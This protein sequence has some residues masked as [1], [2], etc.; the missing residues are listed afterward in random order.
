LTRRILL[1][2]LLLLGLPVAA[3]DDDWPTYRH[4]IRRSGATTASLTLPLKPRWS[5]HA[6]QPRQAWSGPA[7]WDAF[8]A[9]AGLQSMRNFDPCHHLT[10]TGDRVY[11]GSSADDAAHCLDAATGKLQWTFFTNAPVR[12][13]PTISNNLAYFGSDDGHAYCVDASNGNL[14]WKHRPASDHRLVA[15]NENL[16]SPWPIRTGVLVDRGKAWFAASLVPWE[17]SYLCCLDAATGS[18]ENGFITEHRELTLQ[19]AMLAAGDL[20]YVPQGRSA[21]LTFNRADG[22]RGSAIGHAGG[23]LCVLTEGN[24]LLAGPQNQKAPTSLVRLTNLT[25]GKTIA[26]FKDTTRVT[27]AGTTAYLHSGAHLLALDLSATPP[28]ELWRSP[29]P[30][31]SEL[32]ATATH[33]VLGLKDRVTLIETTTGKTAASLDVNGTAHG[34]AATANRLFVSTDRGTIH[35]FAP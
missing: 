32:I 2:S 23:V 13:P 4:D 33:V 28:E 15:N 14:R 19:G 6:G 8:T 34:L 26:T 7:K 18:A 9:N 17:S 27:V 10:I 1:P 25:T 21:P 11:F 5:H 20:I 31:P 16:I 24:Q 30:V 12:L 22:K 29:Q 3:D 35:A